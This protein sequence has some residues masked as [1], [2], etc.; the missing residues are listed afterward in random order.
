VRHDWSANEPEL[1]R[2][3]M[4]A[5]WRAG[6]WLEDRT[7]RMTA[8][9]ILSR[10]EYVNVSVDVIERALIGR[11]MVSPRGEIRDVDNYLAFTA[12]AASFPWRS[13]AVWIAAQ[14]AA[15]MG[16]D[17]KTATQVARDVFRSDLYRENLRDLGVELPAAS[18]RIEGAITTP[19]AAPAE[20]GTL[21]L[22]ND[23]FFDRQVFD[24]SA[25]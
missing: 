24:P 6:R 12:H 14:M 1:T 25:V 5:T 17:R 16:L 21:I 15:R 18:E 4:R 13:Q 22:A 10:P 11:F 20:S 2:R 23:A 3:L 8:A 9:D 7:N 19:T